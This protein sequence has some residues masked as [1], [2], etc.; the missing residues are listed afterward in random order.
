MG[1]GTNSLPEINLGAE[2]LETV[3]VSTYLGSIITSALSLQEEL[4]RE[5]GKATA[6]FKQLV[7]GA[8][9]VKKKEERN[10]FSTRYAYC[11]LSFTGVRHGPCVLVRRG[12]WI[13]YI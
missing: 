1:Q 3:D 7:K 2:S 5:I 11:Q 10:L 13:A 9:G 4:T 6:A 12:G 8:W